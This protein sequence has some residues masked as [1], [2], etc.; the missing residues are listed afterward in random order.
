MILHVFS[1]LRYSVILLWR[2]EAV[3]SRE[4][5]PASPAACGW[6]CPLLDK[7]RPAD[8]VL[9]ADISAKGNIVFRKHFS[10]MNIFK[11]TTLLC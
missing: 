4:G 9:I 3:G 10:P 5:S 6:L 2:E 1:N 11:P 7:A 8:F